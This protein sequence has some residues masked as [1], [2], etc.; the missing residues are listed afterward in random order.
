[1]Q[2]HLGKNNGFI[3]APHPRAITRFS[4]IVKTKRN[5]RQQSDTGALTHIK[6]QLPRTPTVPGR[7]AP[8]N[9]ALP[10]KTPA[11][12][13]PLLREMKITLP[14]P[15]PFPDWDEIMP[16]P[17]S[18][19]RRDPPHHRYLDA[20]YRKERGGRRLG[21]SHPEEE[22]EKTELLLLGFCR[23]TSRESA[24]VRPPGGEKGEGG[25]ARR[26]GGVEL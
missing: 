5:W 13:S 15:I 25:Q 2:L 12:R 23:A 8:S 3:K 14:I 22:E 17:R 9:R 20:N 21:V 26:A 1:V 24:D 11:E 16:P 4:K 19:S 6:Y 18:P 10:Y 7:G